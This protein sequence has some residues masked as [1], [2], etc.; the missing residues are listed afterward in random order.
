MTLT[1]TWAFDKSKIPDPQKR[2]ARMLRFADLLRHPRSSD[3]DKRLQLTP[4]Q[5]RIIERIYGPSDEHGARLARTVF[6]LL[7]RGNRKTTLG[8]VIALGSTIGPEQVTGG[9]VISAASDR[10]GAGLGRERLP[11]GFVDP[12]TLPPENVVIGTGHVHPLRHCGGA[13][14]AFPTS[15]PS[16][17]TW[18]RCGSA[19]E[20]ARRRAAGG[21]ERLVNAIPPFVR[22]P[23]REHPDR[24]VY[25][26]LA[27]ATMKPKRRFGI[28]CEDL[29]AVHEFIAWPKRPGRAGA[30]AEAGKGGRGM[31]MR[32][33]DG[34]TFLIS[35]VALH[36][37]ARRASTPPVPLARLCR[38]HNRVG[39]DAE[40]SAAPSRKWR[41]RLRPDRQSHRRC[42][43]R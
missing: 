29:L 5:R 20:G 22:F 10:S 41:R 8:S 42:A 18:L 35:F 21:L 3:P 19:R 11:A 17:A 28:R 38:G 43:R 16:P 13:N 32:L 27:V 26:L 31:K 23:Y 39:E 33:P 15:R 24:T 37:A 12:A 40:G 36:R 25:G 2:A 1:P 4:W 7:P 34:R 30:R 9:Q 14:C 6:I